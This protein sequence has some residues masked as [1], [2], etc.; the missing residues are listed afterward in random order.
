MK[1]GNYYYYKI[2]VVSRSHGYSFMVRST[3]EL[4]EDEALERAL[5]ANCFEDED[6]LDC[7]IVDTL[8]DDSDIK[9]FADSTTTV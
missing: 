2:D 7:A 9:A 6:D 1:N 8:I 5:S 4:S 3:D